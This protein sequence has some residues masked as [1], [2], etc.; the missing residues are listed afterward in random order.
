MIYRQFVER[1][2][3][4]DVAPITQVCMTFNVDIKA[5]P[6]TLRDE[7]SEWLYAL[8]KQHYLENCKANSKECAEPPYTPKKIVSPKTGRMLITYNVVKNFPLDLQ[9]IVMVYMMDCLE[10]LQKK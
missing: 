5:V 2:K 8:V 9:K 1:S 10:F 4:V 7:M 6:E 3:D